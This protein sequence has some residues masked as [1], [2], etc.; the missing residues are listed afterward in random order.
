MR[1]HSTIA[2]HN[3]KNDFNV[4]GALRAASCYGANLV[5]LGGNRVKRLSNKTADTAKTWRHIPLIETENVMDMVPYGTTPVA[6]ELVDD[7]AS[8]FTFEH[9]ERAFYVFGPEDGSF[10]SDIL[11]RCH[12]RIMIPTR[13]CMNLA[14]TVNVVLYDRLMKQS[15]GQP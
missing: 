4:G 13:V 8:L 11:N 15:G 2:L 10:G 9:P 1:G 12:H 5:V 14:V 3:C 6:V 7:A